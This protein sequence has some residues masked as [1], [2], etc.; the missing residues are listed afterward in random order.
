M[1]LPKQLGDREKAKFVENLAGDVATRT[2]VTDA[3]GADLAKAEDTAHASGD[4]GIQMLGVRN[5]TLA[6]L[7]GTDGDYAPLQLDANGAL[8]VNNENYLEAELVDDTD[9]SAATNYYPSSTGQAMG[10]YNNVCIHG[11]TT[12]GVTFTVEAKIDDSTDWVDITQ[13]GYRMDDNTSGNASLIDQTFMIAFRDLYV[14]EVRIK[15]VTAD[16]TNGVQYH[17]K[18][19]A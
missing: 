18:L 17:W 3:S 1:A 14:R 16:A 15:S 11:V 8:Y 12:G 7:G 5:D 9:V 6:A 13:A 10:K 19:T 2:V 4:T